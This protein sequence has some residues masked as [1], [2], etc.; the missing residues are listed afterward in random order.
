MRTE[1]IFTEKENLRANHAEV[2]WDF[3]RSGLIED[4]V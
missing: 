4:Q 2:F 1:K 3:Y